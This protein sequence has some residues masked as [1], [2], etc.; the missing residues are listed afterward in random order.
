M[1]RLWQ[2]SLNKNEKIALSQKISGATGM[3]ERAVEKDWWVTVALKALSQAQ[4]AYLMYFKGLCIA[5][6]KPLRLSFY[7]IPHILILL[8]K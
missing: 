7:F 3:D 5:T 6:H 1:N 4:C 2:N 8:R